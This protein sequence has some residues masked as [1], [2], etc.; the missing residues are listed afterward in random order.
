MDIDQHKLLI[1]VA[2]KAGVKRY[3]PGEF[4]SNTPDPQ[5][6]EHVP[7]FKGKATIADYLKTKESEGMTWTGIITGGFFDWSV[8]PAL[9]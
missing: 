6:V 4:G 2:V 9:T 8:S 1:D 3:I 7:I 5:V